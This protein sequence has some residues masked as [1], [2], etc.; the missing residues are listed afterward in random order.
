MKKNNPIILVIVLLGLVLSAL[1][2]INRLRPREASSPGKQQQLS[3]VTSFY[4]LY[5]FTSE[6]AGDDI[7]VYNLTPPGI[8]PHDYEPTSQDLIALSHSSLILINGAGLEPWADKIAAGEDGFKLVPIGESLAT[9]SLSA[10]AHTEDTHVR[11]D[12]HVWLSPL[13][14][15][16]LVESIAA[17]LSRVDSVHAANFSNRAAALVSRLQTLNESYRTGLATCSTRNVVT[18]HAAFHYLTAAYNLNQV[19]IAGLSPDAEPTP[20]ALSELADFAKKNQINYIFLESLVAPDLANTLAAE[21]GAKTLV[22]NPLEGLTPEEL[23]AGHDY[24]TEMQSNLT[25]LRLAL[26][27]Q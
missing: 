19:A 26:D 7:A 17:E 3:V 21:V 8:E 22:L 20:R 16:K 12:P 5:F 1:A 4:P 6:I 24:F 10:D 23:A 14:A 15:E 11:R 27:C 13:L 25:N 2:L 18:A 9:R